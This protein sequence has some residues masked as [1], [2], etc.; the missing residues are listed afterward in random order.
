MGCAALRAD[1]R[2]KRMK[3]EPL[4]SSE[5]Q[6]LVT[7]VRNTGASPPS[8]AVQPREVAA[9]DIPTRML[10]GHR[11]AAFL[12]FGRQPPPTRVRNAGAS[13]PSPAAQPRKAAT[14]DNPAVND[15]PTKMLRG[16]RKAAFLVFGRQPAKGA[17]ESSASCGPSLPEAAA[18]RPVAAISHADC[19]CCLQSDLLSLCSA[20]GCGPPTCGCNIVCGLPLGAELGH[21]V[22]LS[23]L[24]GG[25]SSAA[26]ASG[27][28]PSRRRE[29][30]PGRPSQPISVFRPKSKILQM[31]PHLNLRF[32]F[33]FSY[34]WLRPRY[35]VSAEP[36][37]SV[38][39]CARLF[40]SLSPG[41]IAPEKT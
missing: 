32:G 4:V 11:K 25:T 18:R 26:R 24:R 5:P 34:L 28:P 3:A 37:P 41:S 22:A 38:W 36:K 33:D 16:H 30:L 39:F 40:V 17:H 9:K 1:R 13:P 2:Q 35:S 31:R 19:Q 7:K 14:N 23:R 10:R 29:A 27:A 20:R 12:V 21:V 15:I 6:P 8:P